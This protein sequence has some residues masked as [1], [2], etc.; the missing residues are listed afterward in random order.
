[1]PFL[2]YH[3]I[4]IDTMSTTP[5]NTV[6]ET[7]KV[8]PVKEAKVKPVKEA[9]VKP[10]KEAK[11]DVYTEGILHRRWELYKQK[12]IETDEIIRET[13][14]PIRHEN[15]PED[16]TENMAKF[17]IRNYD[18]DPSCKWAKC[19]GLNGDLSSD[20]FTADKPP[21]VKSFTSDGPCSFGPK[22]KFGVIYFLDLRKWKQNK[23]IL[24]KVNATNDSPEWKTLKMNKKETH[25]LQCSDGRRPHI[26]WEKIYEQLN[27][28][29]IKIFDG[30]FEDIFTPPSV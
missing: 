24:W 13:G 26:S 6:K 2:L 17:I 8:K 1:M 12:A 18:N 4:Y 3:K 28:L 22:K 19:M 14:L 9:K 25:E 29:C 23:I 7:T 10:V 16:I 11:T 5:E 27:P 20:K 21:E 30:S 15:P